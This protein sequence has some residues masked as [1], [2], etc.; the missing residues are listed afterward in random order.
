MVSVVGNEFHPCAQDI[1]VGV[2]ILVQP[3][4]PAFLDVWRVRLF[5]E[6]DE[7]GARNGDGHG[8][9]E[10]FEDEILWVIDVCFGYPPINLRKIF[11]GLREFLTGSGA[12]WGRCAEGGGEF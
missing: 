10:V 7:S 8:H 5:G 1:F 4:S 9:E 12:F 2:G 6:F 3:A 11:R